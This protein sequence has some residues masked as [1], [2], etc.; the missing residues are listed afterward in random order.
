M[1]HPMITIRDA[2]QRPARTIDGHADPD[3]AQNAEICGV[4]GS[5]T[6]LPC[7]LPGPPPTRFA[8]QCAQSWGLRLFPRRHRSKWL[9]SPRR[10]RLRGNTN[11]VPPSWLHPLSGHQRFIFKGFHTLFES[12]QTQHATTSI[13]REH[14]HTHQ[15]KSGRILND[16]YSRTRRRSANAK[17]CLQLACIYRRGGSIMG[18]M[19]GKSL[20]DGSSMINI[21]TDPVRS[22]A[23]FV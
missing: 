11:D 4:H 9:V 10:R 7:V 2:I 21:A 5:A 6:P 15:A 13:L 8:A 20:K 23:D 17:S 3:G 22:H 18:I 19:H 14:T 1:N 12:S 16:G